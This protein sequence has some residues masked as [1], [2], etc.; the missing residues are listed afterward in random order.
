MDKEIILALAK[1]LRHLHEE[2]ESNTKVFT[3]RAITLADL[4]IEYFEG[5]SERKPAKTSGV[6]NV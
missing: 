1:R 6:I 4:I 2:N 3:D 5:Q